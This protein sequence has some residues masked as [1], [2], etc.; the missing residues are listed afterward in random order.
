MRDSCPQFGN[1]FWLEQRASKR[2]SRA[3]DASLGIILDSVHC[4]FVILSCTPKSIC[5]KNCS[6][7]GPRPPGDNTPK[8]ENLG[9]EQRATCWTQTSSPGSNR[10]AALRRGCPPQGCPA[11]E[12]P[13]PA[14][15]VPPRIAAQ[16]AYSG[17]I[18]GAHGTTQSGQPSRDNPPV[19]DNP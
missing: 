17:C 4:F 19:P 2:T 6:K 15:F 16:T 14:R 9:V 7:R 1:C 13:G 5:L 18:A 11:V 12:K 8:N 3:Q 10:C